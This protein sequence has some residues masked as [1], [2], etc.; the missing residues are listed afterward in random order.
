MATP[1]LKKKR[2]G[3]HVILICVQSKLG[4]VIVHFVCQLARTKDAQT[5]G[6]ILFLGL[7]VKI[8]LKEINI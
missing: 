7:F 6:K 3:A 1:S 2:G 8:F 5:A 4:V